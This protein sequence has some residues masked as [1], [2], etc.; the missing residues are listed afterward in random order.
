MC[1][2]S[3]SLRHKKLEPPKESLRRLFLVVVWPVQLFEERLLV[4]TGRNNRGHRQRAS[5]S[6]TWRSSS[7]RPSSWLLS[8]Q[9]SS[10]PPSSSPQSHLHPR[11]RDE[12]RPE[13]SKLRKATQESRRYQDHH[14][15]P[16]ELR[17]PKNLP[18]QPRRGSLA[19]KNESHM[20]SF[21]QGL[22]R[23]ATRS[24]SVARIFFKIFFAAVRFAATRIARRSRHR[25]L[26][27][28]HDA[29]SASINTIVRGCC[30]RPTSC[31]SRRQDTRTRSR[32]T[33]LPIAPRPPLPRP[34]P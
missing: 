9:P 10:W 6:C 32:Q 33:H 24:W 8:S 18:W 29:H 34:R 28:A 12:T 23:F 4:L 5:T 17:A 25:R 14:Y 2:R 1:C 30:R 15:L 13:E 20:Q 21:V 3:N 31:S 11:V 26:S 27:S 19:H 22:R 16:S 7:W